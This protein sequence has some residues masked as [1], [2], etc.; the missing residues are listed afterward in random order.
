MKD[1]KALKQPFFAQFL[2]DQ[3]KEEVQAEGG[4]GSLTHP[5]ADNITIPERD[6]VTK[7]A[8]DMAQ[9][10]KY[11]SDGDDDPPTVPA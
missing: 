4:E 2:E 7:P 5:V 8:Y 10:M 9:T 3:L 1:E 11:P 6:A